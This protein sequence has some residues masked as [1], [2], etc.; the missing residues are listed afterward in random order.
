[1]SR[2]NVQLGFISL[3]T[4]GSE[5]LGKRIEILY[6]INKQKFEEKRMTIFKYF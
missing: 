6:N 3:V 2:Y 4:I 1:M 5:H